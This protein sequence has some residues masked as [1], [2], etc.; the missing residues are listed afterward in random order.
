MG[1][2]VSLVGESGSS[3]TTTAKMILRLERPTSGRILF[4][5]KDVWNDLRTYED[6][7]WY[8]RMVQGIIQD[9]YGAFNAFYR[10]DR[11]FKQMFKFLPQELEP[12]KRWKAT[13]KALREVGLNP[14][15]ILGKYPHELSGGEK[16]RV[17]IARALLIN[18]ML[19]VADEP[20]S[21]L[22]ATLRSGILKLLMKLRDERGLS[23]LFITHD[24][25]LA[26]YVSDRIL[27]MYKGRIVEEGTPNEIIE[28]PKHPY[29][30]RLIYDIPL[31]YR[32][33]GDI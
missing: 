33:W 26:H 10:V 27:V 23:I 21:M 16:Q 15:H 12:E 25:G 8:R 5:G 19:L 22:D 24:M 17:M 2:I 20:V 14:H 11:V 18:P 32:K 6:V 13:A 7:L 3:K 4:N 29:T 28:S 9:P 30:K 31:L 1:E